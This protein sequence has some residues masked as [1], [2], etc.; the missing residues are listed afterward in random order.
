M[1]PPLFPVLL[2]SPRLRALAVCA[3]A[4]T[5]CATGCSDST[6]APVPAPTEVMTAYGPVRGVAGDGFV[7]YLG[8]PY[9]APPTGALRFAPP[10]A[11]TPWTAPLDADTRP[12]ACPQVIPILG[13]QTEENCLFVNVHVPAEVPPSGA[14][15]LVWIHGGGFTLGEGVQTDGGTVG[16]VL[17]RE[18][19][20]VVV[21]MNYRLGALGFLSHPA[22][23]RESD[24]GVS[25]NYGL[26]DQVFALEWVRDNIRAFG[27]DPERVTIAGQS[28]GG[29]SV[30]AHLT[31]P[32]SQGLFHAAIV[33]SGPCERTMTLAEGS[34]QG[35]RFAAAL[36]TPC[37]TGTDSEVLACLRST[38]A[39]DIL[40]TLPS[41]RDFL[42][43]TDDTAFWGP[44]VD[45][46]VLPQSIG[47]AI[48]AGNV[49]DVPVL[50]GF[51]ENEG[52]VFAALSEVVIAPADYESALTDLVGGPGAA[53]DAVIAAYP[54]DGEDPTV[55]YF[56]AI[57]DQLLTCAARS[58]IVAL[59][60]Q[61]D[62]YEYYYRYPDAA[63]QLPTDF[64]L[65]AYHAAEVQFVFGYRANA[66]I[67]RFN[68]DEQT[69]HD[70]IRSYWGAFVREGRPD[71]TGLPAW[72]KYNAAVD[73]HLVLDLAVETGTG[74]AAA[75]CA[76]WD[77]L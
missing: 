62:L 72:P 26:L 46:D 41:S 32:R 55:R 65:G 36:P 34:A 31:S 48:R 74:A 39:G 29:V 61:V 19:G 63:F 8:I 38:S 28:A 11:P 35:E 23:T 4:A 20:I 60:A 16:D 57:G 45:G 54:L 21:S 47:D 64:D 76:V 13:A 56:D 17:A 18:E 3:L 67:R 42:T 49:P 30:C 24:D 51:T 58:S 9:A 10:A 69:M 1:R 68:E 33:E 44:V 5:L 53:A 77:A 2:H 73:N 15:V 25:G 52:R 40:A 70:I 43:R 6:P 66:F 50:A 14:P 12:R 37:D 27:G 7:G 59:G 71:A 22:L 75:R